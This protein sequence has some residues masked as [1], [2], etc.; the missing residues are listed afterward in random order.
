VTREIEECNRSVL[1]PVPEISDGI[2]HLP[3]RDIGQQGHLKFAG[4]QNPLHRLSVIH[5]IPQRSLGIGPVPDHQGHARFLSHR[6]LSGRP[7]LDGAGAV[8]LT[9][10]GEWGEGGYGHKENSQPM[11][12]T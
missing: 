12:L 5:G 9:L 4:F 1:N 6:L 11:R 2:L 7:N 3:L 10:Q 8:A